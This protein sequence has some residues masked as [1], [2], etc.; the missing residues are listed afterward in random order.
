MQYGGT[1]LASAWALRKSGCQM[2]FHPQDE[3]PALH[4][5][6]EAAHARCSQ[7]LKVKNRLYTQKQRLPRGPFQSL[8]IKGSSRRHDAFLI[9]HARSR[10][11]P[12]Q[13]LN[14]ITCSASGRFSSPVPQYTSVVRPLCAE[15]SAFSRVSNFSL[16]YTEES[17]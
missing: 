2:Q 11:C 17:S 16:G 14:K 8:L 3:E 7:P 12:D 4:P 5:E 10:R 15:G 13:R 1:C 9:M 6:T